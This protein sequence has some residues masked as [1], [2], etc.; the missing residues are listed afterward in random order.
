MVHPR[1]PGGASTARRR[2]ESGGRCRAT[3]MLHGSLRR[4]LALA[5]GQ[6]RVPRVCDC[7]LGHGHPGAHLG[8]AY[9]TGMRRC[10]FRWNEWGFRLGDGT[11]PDRGGHTHRSQSGRGPG[12][13]AGQTSPMLRAFS[14]PHDPGEATGR[15]RS[16]EST[17]LMPAIWALATA[18]ERLA[19]V[20]AEHNSSRPRAPRA[21]D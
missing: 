6:Y 5:A 10:W 16:P 21:G 2:A 14:A 18:L 8:L 1:P 4:S 13:A 15:H 17:S 9:D 11:P 12:R 19:D 7:R 3:V 20:I